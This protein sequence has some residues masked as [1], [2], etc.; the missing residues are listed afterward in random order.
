MEKVSKLVQ[1]YIRKESDFRHHYISSLFLKVSYS[2]LQFFG[3]SV[4]KI[5]LVLSNMKVCHSTQSDIF[6]TCVIYL[7]ATQ[8]LTLSGNNY[9]SFQ[10][11]TVSLIIV[12]L[13]AV[14]VGVPTKC[15]YNNDSPP[16]PR[17]PPV[18]PPPKPVVYHAQAPT[19]TTYTIHTYHSPAPTPKVS[20]NP[21]VVPVVPYSKPSFSAPP[22]YLPPAAPPPCNSYKK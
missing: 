10:T 7:A 21:R 15:C 3:L 13:A 5:L 12:I 8:A 14:A 20:A 11:L 9:F 1:L 19:M 18:P 6:K 2:S 17:Y 4:E 16:A 22:P